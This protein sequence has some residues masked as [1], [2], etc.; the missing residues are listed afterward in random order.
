MLT[1]IY[2]VESTRKIV[3]SYFFVGINFCINFFI[4][5]SGSTNEK[6]GSKDKETFFSKGRG[7]LFPLN[8]INDNA[9]YVL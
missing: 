9:F 3:S 1:N 4:K 7:S 2:K 8:V 5:K 6:S